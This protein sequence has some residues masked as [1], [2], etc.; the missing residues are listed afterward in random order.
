MSETR[1]DPSKSTNSQTPG[2]SNLIRLLQSPR[3]QQQLTIVGQTLLSIAMA[4]LI[5]AGLILIV[6]ENPLAAYAALFK[7][8]FGTGPALARTLRVSSPLILSGLA[9]AVAF[10]SGMINLGVEGSLYLGAFTAALAGIYIQG[11]PPIV[12]FPLALL[13]GAITGGIWAF[14]PGFLKARAGVDEIVA[15]LMLNYVAVLLVDYLVLTYFLDPVIGTTSDRPATVPIPD[16]AKLPFI[17]EKYGLT[18][19]IIIGVVIALILAWMYLRSI[20][21]FESDMNGFNRRFAH[22]GGI[23]TIK[24]DLISMVLSGMLGGLAGATESLGV[25]GRYVSGFSTGIGFD[26][27]AVALMGHLNPIGTIL[28]AVFFGALKNGGA[29]MEL[30]TNVPRDVILVVEGLILMVVTARQLFVFL[31][32]SAQ[33]SKED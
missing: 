20:W 8:A 6:G 19:G 3:Q 32:L 5:G 9:I 15:T 18:V 12:H 10:R 1:M 2:W 25:Y 26:G 14:F 21:G 13:V 31:R 22:F 17:S 30:A 28:G 4:L 29:S 23:N 16:S 11:L 33:N 27:I 7:G 24:V